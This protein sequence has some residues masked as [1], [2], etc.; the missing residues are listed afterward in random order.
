MIKLTRLN[1][2]EIVVN[3]ELIQYIEETPDTVITLT[4][5]NKIVVL[6]NTSDII[7]KVID[8]KRRLGQPAVQ[9]EK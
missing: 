2:S 1:K 7:E 6:E 9:E 4:T 3:A 5:G 8:F